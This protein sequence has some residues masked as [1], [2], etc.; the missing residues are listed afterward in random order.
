[1]FRKRL[2]FILVSANLMHQLNITTEART[3]D[4]DISKLIQ[5][6]TRFYTMQN[7]EHLIESKDVCNG[8]TSTF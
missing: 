4:H 1:M 3:E 5:Q 7:N 2:Q 6:G 8:N